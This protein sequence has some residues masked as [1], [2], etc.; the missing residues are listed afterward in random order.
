[1]RQH[2]HVLEMKFKA[3]VKRAEMANVIDIYVSGTHGQVGGSTVLLFCTPTQDWYSTI[4]LF[5]FINYMKFYLTCVDISG[6]AGGRVGKSPWE[7]AGSTDTGECA[8]ALWDTCV[9]HEGHG[10]VNWMLLQN[11]LQVMAW[12]AQQIATCALVSLQNALHGERQVHNLWH[13][14]EREVKLAGQAATS[15]SQLGRLLPLQR[16]HWPCCPGETLTFMSFIPRG[17]CK[18]GERPW[19]GSFCGGLVIN[20][21][22]CIESMHNCVCRFVRFVYLSV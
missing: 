16:Q 22:K 21:T 10:N 14:T 1:M 20:N 6:Y 19:N 3:G 12:E 5:Q 4:I 7:P 13:V 18:N 15:G 2:P 11:M 9:N 17:H 8:T